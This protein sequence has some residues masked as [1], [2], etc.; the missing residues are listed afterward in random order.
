MAANPSGPST[1]RVEARTRIGC[2]SRRLCG[3]CQSPGTGQVSR[4]R[5][6]SVHAVSSRTRGRNAA[7]RCRLRLDETRGRAQRRRCR[8][9]G[10]RA[11]G[12]ASTATVA[13]AV[14][15]AGLRPRP[16]AI[17]A[18]VRPWESRRTTTPPCGT[19]GPRRHPRLRAAFGGSNV[20]GRPAPERPSTASPVG[21]VVCR[22][23][24]RFARSPCSSPPGDAAASREKRPKRWG[25]LGLRP[26]PR[27]LSDR[28]V[29][30]V[31]DAP[32]A[33]LDRAVD[34]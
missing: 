19:S 15:A 6:A 4:T 21:W 7:S 8:G 11:T 20:D 33:Q 14:T 29:S 32:V 23:R 12:P 18:L 9:E 1:L 16:S 13:S 24:A 3:P 26:R 5:H 17:S 27:T 28:E 10:E 34:F 2:S 22:L 30:S 25:E 31:P